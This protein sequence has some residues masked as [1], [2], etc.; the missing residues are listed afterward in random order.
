MGCKA[1]V[2]ID[3]GVTGSIGIIHPNSITEF[4][5]T[6]VIKERSYTKEKQFIHRIDWEKLL[7]IIPIGSFVLIERP[8]INPRAFK[9]SSSA[10]RAL[11]STLIVMT[12][13][14]C[15][16]KYIDSKEWQREFISSNIIGHDALKEASKKIGIELFPE[17]K[18]NILK[19]EDAD[20]ILIAEYARRQ[21]G[22]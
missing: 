17:H 10:L 7:S 6:P 1:L 20:G 9:S 14:D 18:E 2:G 16:Y 3:N 21:Y 12:I 4:L 5:K 15:A 13:Q 19:H 11:E 8:M 22:F